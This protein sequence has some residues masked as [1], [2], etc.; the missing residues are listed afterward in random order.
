VVT[1]K[2]YTYQDLVDALNHTVAYDWNSLLQGNLLATRPTP[3]SPGLEAAGWTVTYTD[4]PNQAAVDAE[5]VSQQ[6]D[7]SASIG[8]IIDQD[9][10]IVDVAP[11]SAA[12]RAGLSPGS[13]LM[14]VNHR[15]YSADLLRQSIVGAETTSQPIELLTLTDGYY[16]DFPVDYHQGLRSPHLTRIS[17]KPDLLTTILQSRRTD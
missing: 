6:A 11:D 8:L 12:G 14:G 16:A 5:S 3:V 15:V 1:V 4:E 10:S 2:P 17:G 9:G 7:L 13:K